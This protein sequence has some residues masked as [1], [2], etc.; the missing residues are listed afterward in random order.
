MKSFFF[1]CDQRDQRNFFIFSYFFS[2]LLSLF[3]FGWFGSFLLLH[4]WFLIKFFIF[5]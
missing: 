2:F 1:W 5:I 3:L 4:Y